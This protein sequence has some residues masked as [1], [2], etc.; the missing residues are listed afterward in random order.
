MSDQRR[1]S[2]RQLEQLRARLSDRDMLV[3][4]SLRRW[5]LL[6]PIHLCRLHFVEH[7]SAESAERIC[8]RTMQRLASHNLVRALERRIGGQRAGSSGTI[9]A[10]APTGWRILG[11]PT[12][13]RWHEPGGTHIAH[14]LAIAE[15]GTRLWQGAVVRVEHGLINGWTIQPEPDAWRRFNQGHQPRHLKPDLYIHLT[16]KEREIAWFI[17]ID[18]GTE[19]PCVIETKANAYHDYLRTGDEQD[20]L[21]FF[22]RVLWATTGRQRHGRQLDDVLSDARC[23]PGLHHVAPIDRADQLIWRQMRA[24]TTSTP[25]G[26]PMHGTRPNDNQPT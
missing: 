22:P 5:R 24:T 14:T 11:E 23:P 2:R 26:D 20:R 3:L 10:L 6:Q 9:W 13:K 18:R 21:G 25:T 15:L 8:R 7:A 17:E 19:A 4:T 12:R 1:I 16:S